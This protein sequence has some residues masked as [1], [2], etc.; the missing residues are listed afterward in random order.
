MAT[1][2]HGPFAG[3]Y[4]ASISVENLRCFSEEQTLHLLTPEGHPA[5]WTLL[6]GANGT[7]KTT[8]LQ[9]MAAASLDPRELNPDRS[10]EGYLTSR[11]FP[12][13]P[14]PHLAWGYGAGETYVH[15]VFHAKA[16]LAGALERVVETSIMLRDP[17]LGLP[18]GPSSEPYELGGATL[19]ATWFGYGPS[20]RLGDGALTGEPTAPLAGLWADAALVNAEEWFLQL[21]YAAANPRLDDAE[22]KQAARTR[23]RLEALL[24][25]VLPEVS[26][27]VPS[28]T[29]GA[30]L[31]RFRLLAS[32]PFGAI[33][34]SDLGLGYQSTLAW[35][36]DLAARM[37]AA[38]PESDAPF[39]E[40]A[41]VLVDEIDLHLHPQWQRVLLTELSRR[42]PNVQ[43]V[44]T[45]HNPLI[46]QAAPDA[47][48]AVLRRE[49]EHVVIDQS[50]P[51]VRHWRIDQIL[52]SDLFGLPSARDSSLDTRLAER[53]RLLAKATL[54]PHDERRLAELRAELGALPG[55]DSPWEMR[56]MEVI[57]RAAVSL[58]AEG[59]G[60]HTVR[61][62][63]APYTKAP[64][65]GGP[66]KS[67]TPR[68]GPRKG[69]E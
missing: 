64:S 47:C 24:R 33:P 36:T 43:F 42:F 4:L 40:P 59:R 19:R 2:L 15:A 63:S 20:R 41:V 35:V 25:A 37:I 26:E 51:N 23:D 14:P 67:S 54:T 53:D 16:T 61:E 17:A 49:G 52:T 58:E 6:L 7:G 66:K 69:G 34:V 68:K 32:T 1:P 13:R 57:R 31:G 65:A 46:V 60:A 27:F 56:A 29:A 55:G 8:L 21:D 3:A 18:D 9:A 44:A 22:R 62:S 39:S 45:T 10:S 12:S 5:R 50:L 11:G 28:R 48:L 30:D 38:Y